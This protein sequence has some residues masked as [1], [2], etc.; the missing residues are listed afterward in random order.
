MRTAA[1]RSRL[2]PAAQTAA[3]ASTHGRRQLSARR[4]FSENLP[5]PLL[6]SLLRL[7]L[8]PLKSLRIAPQTRSVDAMRPFKTIPVDVLPLLAA[9]CSGQLRV[10]RQGGSPDTVVAGAKAAGSSA[11]CCT[12][13]RA[14]RAPAES[15][16]H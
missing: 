5:E 1:A 10:G 9:T 13:C 16:A 11:D 8:V 6:P 3:Q 7:S 14:F 2:L 4:R 12:A 15:P